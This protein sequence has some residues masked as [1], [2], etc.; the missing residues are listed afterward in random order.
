[1][2]KDPKVQEA[3]FL[4]AA[5][6]QEIVAD[7]CHLIDI[8]KDLNMIECH[9]IGELHPSL[10]KI[11]GSVTQ[12]FQRLLYADVFQ[13]PIPVFQHLYGTRREIFISQPPCK[14]VT[15]KLLL[16]RRRGYDLFKLDN[17]TRVK[18]GE[19]YDFSQSSK[20]DAFS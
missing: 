7:Y 4:K 19:L 17:D 1:L 14:R 2:K 10:R 12:N 3:L 9:D 8:E 20:E 18:T 5:E 16:H 6:V 13:L 15:L 11:R